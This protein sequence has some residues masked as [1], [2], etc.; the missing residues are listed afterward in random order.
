LIRSEIA[1][2][3]DPLNA[4]SPILVAETKR[5][6]TSLPGRTRSQKPTLRIRP[7][8]G[9]V[10]LNI[11]ELWQYRD[12]LWILVER[13]IKV[14]YKQT[15]LGMTWVA[16]QPLIAAIILAVIFGRVA[17]L[18]SDGAPYL[19]FV[20][21]RFDCLEL[22]FACDPAKQQQSGPRRSACFKSLLPEDAYSSFTYICRPGRF[23]GHAGHVVRLHGGLSSAP[24]PSVARRPRIAVFDRDDSYSRC[25]VVFRLERKVSRL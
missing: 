3:V 2:K 25:S 10:A 23:C 17:K 11:R 6:V 8:K 22:L 12:L 9:W 16:L 20:F 15:A 18:P 5:P 19:L 13:D 24:H 4:E 21:L 14:I 1:G 7:T